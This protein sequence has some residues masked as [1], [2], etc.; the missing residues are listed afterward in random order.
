MIA[1]DRKRYEQAREA[2]KTARRNGAKIGA[3]PYRGI[4]KLVR[5]LH[6][7][8]ELGWREIDS[9]RKGGAR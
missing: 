6:S 1:D 4:T 2:G 9:A 3:N 8:W 5:D 7:E